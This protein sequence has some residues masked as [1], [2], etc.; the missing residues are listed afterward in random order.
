MPDRSRFTPEPGGQVELSSAAANDPS[1]WANLDRDIVQQDALH[2]DRHSLADLKATG[3][4]VT[5]LLDITGLRRLPSESTSTCR[6][7]TPA[8]T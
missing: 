4:P 7:H 1:R 3:I 5:P 2:G 8:T 6:Q